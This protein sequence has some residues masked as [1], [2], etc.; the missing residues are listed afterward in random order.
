VVYFEGPDQHRGWFNSSLM[1]GM[2]ATGQ[3]PFTDV[4]THGWVLD[5]DG[6]AM[7]KS[8][9]NVIS[10]E[11]VI[12][13]YGADIVRWWALAT[14]WRS[15]VR[16]GDEI[17]QRVAEAYRKVRNTFRFLLGNLHDF[18]P[19]RAVPPAEL[20]AVD[21][22]FAGH[23]AA[24][25]ARMRQDYER[26]LYHR[27][28]DGLLE[29]CTVDLSSVFLDA[30]KD[31]L[32]TL[33]PGDPARRSAQTVLWQALHDLTIAASP[34]LVFTAEEVW[35]SHPALV[36]ESESVHL[37]TWPEPDAALP[38]P[39]DW[40]LLL[41]VRSAT[42]AAIEP[43]RA[44][45]T[46]GTTLEA[47]V[48]LELPAATARRLEPFAPELAGFL[49]VARAEVGETTGSVAVAP[50]VV[51]TEMQRCDRCWTYRSDVG[52]SGE[53]LLCARCVTVLAAAP[54]AA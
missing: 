13:R 48:R 18:D 41:E 14:D 20:T 35:Q 7:H 54:P 51:R 19:A 45:R 43:M 47:E 44:A 34:I 3:P 8:L 33:S 49:L 9:G 22:A 32:Y 39:E 53:G 38:S 16:I 2:G 42:N 50:Q 24:R 1:I 40:A 17:L 5:G 25:V 30:A 12:Q 29:L 28:A 36:R 21:R 27:V 15:D 10:P 52:P 11:A 31:R 37:A 4:L 26:F 6:R 46:L 23:L